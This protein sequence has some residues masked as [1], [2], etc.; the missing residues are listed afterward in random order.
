MT[1]KYFAHP[2]VVYIDQSGQDP[3]EQ[4]TLSCQYMT[5]LV[6]SSGVQK[7][8]FGF[9]REGFDFNITLLVTLY[10]F[11]ELDGLVATDVWF[12]TVIGIGLN[13]GRRELNGNLSKLLVI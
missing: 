13:C 11:G 3:S 8:T 9:D 4:F 5:L 10:R 12:V 1:W 6:M 2:L 7:R